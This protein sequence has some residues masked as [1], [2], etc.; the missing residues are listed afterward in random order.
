MKNRAINLGV[1]AEP[2]NALVLKYDDKES[3]HYLILSYMA[4]VRL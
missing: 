3:D 1:I 4:G 2:V